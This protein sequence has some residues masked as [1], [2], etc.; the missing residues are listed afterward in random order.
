MKETLHNRNQ[1]ELVNLFGRVGR[2]HQSSKYQLPILAQQN[3]N[4]LLVQGLII[5]LFSREALQS[6]K[7]ISIYLLRR[8]NRCLH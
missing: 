4:R 2:R 7:L 6:D 3:L 5:G 1:G 8:L